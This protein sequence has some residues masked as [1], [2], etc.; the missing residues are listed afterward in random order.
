MSSKR[1]M[2]DNIQAII[3]AAEAGG[4]ELKKYSFRS[5]GKRKYALDANYCKQANS[6]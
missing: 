1:F 3:E 6:E 5:E 4:Q 2:N